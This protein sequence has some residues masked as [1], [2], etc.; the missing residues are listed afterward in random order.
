MSSITFINALLVDKPG[1]TYTVVIN[2]SRILSIEP[3]SSTPAVAFEGGEVVDLEGKHYLGPS[4]MDAHTHFT[5]W[6]LNRNRVDLS[7]AESA[8]EAIELMRQAGE[9]GDSATPLVG[10]D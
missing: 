2:N 9:G 4:L 8:E 7:H 1:T 3:S 10:R 5:A 6:T